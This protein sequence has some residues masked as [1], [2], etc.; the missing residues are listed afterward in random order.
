M[1]LEKSIH[2]KDER[3]V[4]LE[5]ALRAVLI[6]HAGG[7]FTEQ[8]RYDFLAITGSTECTTTALCDHIRELLKWAS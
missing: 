4:Q 2:E 1:S 5:N 7:E 8:M 6:F 3:I